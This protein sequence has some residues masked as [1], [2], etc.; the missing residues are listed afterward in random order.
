MSF[1]IYISTVECA[2]GFQLLAEAGDQ[3]L[4]LLQPT[5]AGNAG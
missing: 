5:N 4:F 3:A 1:T 2:G